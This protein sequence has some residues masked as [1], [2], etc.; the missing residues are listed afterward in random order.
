MPRVATRNIFVHAKKILG[1]I[2]AIAQRVSNRSITTFD[3]AMNTVSPTMRRRRGR[4]WKA[5]AFKM[6]DVFPLIPG[7]IQSTVRLGAFLCS[8]EDRPNES[9]V[10]AGQGSLLNIILRSA[11]DLW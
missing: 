4:F 9:G 6:C 7:L 2:R 5:S 10:S 8:R 1:G 3:S 11:K